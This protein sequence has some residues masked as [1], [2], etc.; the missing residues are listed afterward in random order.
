MLNNEPLEISTKQTNPFPKS[1]SSDHTI[2]YFLE[3]IKKTLKLQ[4]IT[5]AGID[6]I[7][8]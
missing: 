7:V 2:T 4:E 3:H 8:N 6:L 1:A 5:K